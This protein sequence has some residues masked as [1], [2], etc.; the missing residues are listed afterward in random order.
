MKL[1]S[2]KDELAG[3]LADADLVFCYSA[4]LGW[5]AVAVLGPLGAKTSVSN[6][7]DV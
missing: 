3:S 1:G 5:D 6:D 7:F 2:L 4:G